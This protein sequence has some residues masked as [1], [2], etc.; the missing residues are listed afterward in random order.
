[1]IP[2]NLHSRGCT[3]VFVVPEAPRRAPG[4]RYNQENSLEQLRLA[5]G[6]LLVWSGIIL[7][8]QT[9]LHVQSTTM[10]TIY[11]DTISKQHMR[12]GVMATD[13]LFLDDNTSPP[14]ASECLEEEGIT[15]LELPALFP[16]L[17]PIKSACDM[18]G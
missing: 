4:T 11:R 8:S 7:G 1:M 18:L 3:V 10:I 12:K 15:R 16:D 2:G 17:N 9:I 6:G 14:R 5:S 13:F